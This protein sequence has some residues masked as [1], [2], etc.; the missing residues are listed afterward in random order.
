MRKLWISL[1]VVFFLLLGSFYIFFPSKISFDDTTTARCT[2]VGAARTLADQSTWKKWWPSAGQSE[3]DGTFTYNHVR[4]HVGEKYYNGVAVSIETDN[5]KIT[6][7]INVFH[8]TTDS[9]AIEWVAT[10]HSSL[11]PLKKL[12]QRKEAET[13][14]SNTPELLQK[15]REFLTKKENI[16]G[17]PI[18]QTSTKD[19]ILIFTSASYPEKPG[20]AE[21][22]G[23]IEVL[24]KYAAS[25]G[26]TQNGDPLLNITRMGPHTY[27]TRVAIPLDKY[28]KGTDKIEPKRMVPGNFLMTEVVGGEG[29]VDYAFGQIKQFMQ[30]YG[31]SVVAIPF[32]YLVTDRLAE[33]DSSKWV[34]KI[35]QPIYY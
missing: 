31:K 30:D 8:L 3:A 28:I 24:K 20:Y 11:N 17:I 13:I 5:L 19:T 29:T 22:Y 16:Y 23:L 33:K 26:C 10:G 21:I 6:S 25:H 15:M 18:T 4:Y 32:Q 1:A 14:Q 35:Y 34:T 9:T 12:N 2:S 7:R 27:L